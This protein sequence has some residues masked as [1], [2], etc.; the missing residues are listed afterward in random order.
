MHYSVSQ[1][2]HVK[3]NSGYTAQN[4]DGWKVALL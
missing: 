3:C 1:L 4:K 2:V